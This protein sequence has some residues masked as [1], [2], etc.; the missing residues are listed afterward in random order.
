MKKMLSMLFVAFFM[1]GCADAS[2]RAI[3]EFKPSKDNE[4]HIVVFYEND[5][6]EEAYQSSLNGIKVFLARK[7]IAA[8]ISYQQIEDPKNYRELLQVEPKQIV[9]F[10]YKGVRLK[11]RSPE[12]LEGM[13]LQ[14]N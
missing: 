4:W 7:N 12:V 10:D 13:V 8:K 2:G 3:E 14:L 1:A 5:P 11:A 6:P 9:V